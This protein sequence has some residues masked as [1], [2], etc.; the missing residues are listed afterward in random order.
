MSLFGAL[1]SGV[2]GLNANAHA[3]GIISDNIANVNTIGYKVTN[4]RF[5]TLVTESATATRYSPGGVISTPL[6]D[7]NRQGLMQATSSPTDIAI[8]GS[9]LF[10][11]N[12][13]ANP[14]ST[15]GEYLF[16]RAGAFTP[17]KDG[18]LRNVAG[19][20]LQG[21]ALDSE[22]K[23]ADKGSDLTSLTTVNISGLTGTAEATTA[24]A[25]RANLQSSLAVSPAEATYDPAS[26][27]NNMASG[28]VTPDFQRSISIFDSKGGTRTLTLS[29]LKSAIANQWH[30][31]VHVE[32]PTDVVAAPPLVDGQVATGIL[33]FN[34]DGTLD[35]ASTTVP[36]TLGITWEPLL[37]LEDSTI[38]LDLGSDGESD[39]LTQFDAPSKLI[40][41]DV[42][43]ALF[44][45]LTG[46]TISEEG[47]VTALF[48]NG[49]Q[50]HIYKLAIA[51]F[52]N[53]AGLSNETGTTYALSD[54]AGDIALLEPGEGGAGTIVASA[55]E[56]STVD[57]AQ[58]FTNMIVTQRA[59][60]AASKIITTTNEML[61]ELI[62]IIR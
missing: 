61:D 13:V 28:T 52:P 41:S 29:F 8:T 37:G 58:E 38:A 7:F 34:T 44:G 23:I 59:Y 16:T 14:T 49:T 46:I 35:A 47:F 27:T 20:Y 40:S 33:A 22:G 45:T 48:S 25:L 57:I 1:F 9:G 43:G 31:E 17:D 32:P 56:A 60:S 50:R 18:F 30:V 62:R 26:S 11:V 10:V 21:W 24:I 42:D 53:P 5:S 39:G 6:T 12:R 2:S 36:A 15:S 4:A 51:S 54:R 55:L 19:F 3:M